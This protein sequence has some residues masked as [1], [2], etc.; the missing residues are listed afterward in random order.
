[1]KR[2]LPLVLL[3]IVVVLVSA[4]SC[5]VTRHYFNLN[6]EHS[7][8]SSAKTDIF[9]QLNLTAEQ[10][11]KISTVCAQFSV[12]QHQNMALMQRYNSELA[13]A[14]LSDKDDSLRVEAAVQKV[15]E[16]MG[17]MQKTTLATIFAAK[18]V[19]TPE[20]YDRLL[21]LVAQQLANNPSLS[22]S[23]CP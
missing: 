18:E 2:T 7:V 8:A 23:C 19:L 4:A 21:H 13:G 12:R 20:Q 16:A 10:Q 9:S 17:D 5:L 22:D 15:H 1:M 3:L 14:I 11:H 6:H